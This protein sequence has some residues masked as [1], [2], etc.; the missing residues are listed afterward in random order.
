MKTAIASSWDT[1]A[2]FSSLATARSMVLPENA[3]ENVSLAN[4]CCS[5][6]LEELILPSDPPNTTSLYLQGFDPQSTKDKWGK[7]IPTKHAIYQ[8]AK[9]TASKVIVLCY[10][11]DYVMSCTGKL[12]TLPSSGPMRRVRDTAGVGSLQEGWVDENGAAVGNIS[13]LVQCGRDKG[14]PIGWLFSW[15]NMATKAMQEPKRRVV[16]KACL[17][18]MYRVCPCYL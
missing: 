8:Q 6:F 10:E 11:Y 18:A 12:W 2:N 3:T 13:C 14:M 17:L 5:T 15:E 1:G 16:W 4:S 7:I 9:E